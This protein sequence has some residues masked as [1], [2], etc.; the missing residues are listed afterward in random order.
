MPERRSNIACFAALAITAAGCNAI[1]DNPEGLLVSDADGEAPDVD[2]TPR[3][4]AGAAATQPDATQPD[5]TQPDATQPDASGGPDGAPHDAA[6][7]VAQETGPGVVNCS[8]GGS[9]TPVHVATAASTQTIVSLAVADPYL[10]F[11]VNDSSLS[12]SLVYRV[13][14]GGGSPEE[15]SLPMP[16]QDSKGSALQMIVTDGSYVY[17]I[18]GGDNIVSRMSAVGGNFADFATTNGVEY[19]AW[20]RANSTS[21]VLGA[22]LSSNYIES[23]SRSAGGAA[24][25]IVTSLTVSPGNFEVDDAYVYFLSSTGSAISRIPVGGGGTSSVATADSGESIGR[26]APAGSQMFFSSSTRVG[27]APTGGGNASTVDPGGAAFGLVA[28]GSRILFFRP[29][30]VTDA[31]APCA[32]GA[33]L[34]S[35]PIAGGA[36]VH[37]ATEPAVGGGG[38]PSNVVNDATAVYWVTG[39]GVHIEQMPKTGL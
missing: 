25:R 14:T 9:C 17:G 33:L 11:L 31:S 10:Y 7:D 8:T 39:D 13:S 29:N 30:G 27:V 4:A 36:R 2:G 34:Y 12:A 32:S 22:G 19:V 3:D 37:A 20:L 38:C 6:P 5:A 24:A 15:L 21:L 18:A 23:V 16:A 35:I 26:L 1:L 28:D